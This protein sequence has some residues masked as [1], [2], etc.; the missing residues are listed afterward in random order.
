V[1]FSQDGV[2]RQSLTPADIGKKISDVHYE[3]Y[4]NNEVKGKA[5]DAG[6]ER[7]FCMVK[8][9]FNQERCHACHDKTKRVLGVLDVCLNMSD[10]KLRWPGTATRCAAGIMKTDGAILATSLRSGLLAVLVN[11]RSRI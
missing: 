2:I 1:I 9:L 8:P 4:L 6:S 3:V 7:Q 5:Y 11:R 10:A